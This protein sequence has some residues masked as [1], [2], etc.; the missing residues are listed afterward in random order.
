VTVRSR[1]VRVLVPSLWYVKSRGIGKIH[2][3]TKARVQA[4]LERLESIRFGADQY[5]KSGKHADDIDMISS[6]GAELR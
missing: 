5:E 1:V 4:A 6:G 2:S 3:H